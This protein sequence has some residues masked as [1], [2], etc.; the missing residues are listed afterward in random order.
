MAATKKHDCHAVTV[1]FSTV[2]GTPL[3]KSGFV[4]CSHSFFG[5]YVFFS[6][7]G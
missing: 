6:K 3:I 5:H 7:T 4:F 1:I 2:Y